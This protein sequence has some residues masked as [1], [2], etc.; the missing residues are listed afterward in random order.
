M[1]T[2]QPNFLELLT[3]TSDKISQICTKLRSLIT[4]ID[5]Q[6]I[7]IVCPRQ[8]IAG[9]GVGPK[10]MT[11]HYVYLA[12][13]LHHVNLG[14]YRGALL[15]D[16]TNMLKGTGK[17]MRHIKISKLEQID[18]PEIINLIEES[19]SERKQALGLV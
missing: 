15:N 7:E 4:K 19:I 18:N 8:H 14:F 16:E 17:Q 13:Q 6:S 9:Y 5:P 1:A 10:K 2:N 12:P 3:Q 11:E